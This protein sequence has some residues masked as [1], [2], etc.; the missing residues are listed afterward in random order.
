M[1]KFKCKKC[2]VLM[3]IP[4]RSHADLCYDCTYLEENPE[5][6]RV[7]INKETEVWK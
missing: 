7:N 4:K 6:M 1:G 2:G 3:N 5:P